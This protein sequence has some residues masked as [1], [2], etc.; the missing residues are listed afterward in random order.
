MS[1]R[2]QR[3]KD[4]VLNKIKSGELKIVSDLKPFV[5][6]RLGLKPGNR[7]TP[8]KIEGVKLH[9]Y[10]ISILS[11]KVFKNISFPNYF[12]NDLNVLLNFVKNNGLPLLKFNEKKHMF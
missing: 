11:T 1:I 10:L 7:A 9:K 5:L 2:L 8:Q 12:V 3:N 4:D 6:K